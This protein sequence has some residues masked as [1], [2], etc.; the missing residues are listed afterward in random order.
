MLKKAK[1]AKPAGKAVA[2]RDEVNK[3][4]YFLINRLTSDLL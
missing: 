1:F 4:S 2:F 3:I